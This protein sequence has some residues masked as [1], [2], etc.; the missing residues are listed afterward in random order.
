M[1][2]IDGDM[3]PTIKV[4]VLPERESWSNLVSLDSLN[5]ATDLL[6]VVERLAITFPRVVNDWL[7]FL[8]SLKWSLSIVS[9]LFTFSEPAKSHKFSLAFWYRIYL[10]L[11][12]AFGIWSGWLQEYL[13]DGMRTTTNRIHW[14]LSCFPILLS[15]FHQLKAIQVMS[16]RVLR[17]SFDKDTI[18]FWFMNIQSYWLR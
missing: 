17:E 2:F 5:G 6:F 16:N 15:S 18:N 4:K 12:H 13:K 10:Y 3:F 11:K 8:S 14:S 9:V 1:F 7:M